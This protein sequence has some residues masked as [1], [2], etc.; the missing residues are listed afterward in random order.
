M[1]HKHKPPQR[2]QK[3]HLLWLLLP[4]WVRQLA[5][6][7]LT[8]VPLLMVVV[9]GIVVEQVETGVAETPLETQVQERVIPLEKKRAD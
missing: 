7:L 9:V 4:E 8:Q 1:L 2:P 5:K 3:P 6:P